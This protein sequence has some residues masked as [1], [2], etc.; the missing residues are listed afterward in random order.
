MPNGAEKAGAFDCS[1]AHLPSRRRYAPH[2]RRSRSVTKRKYQHAYDRSLSQS[3][4][5]VRAAVTS[6]VAKS[7]HRTPAVRA[8]ALSLLA[9]IRVLHRPSSLPPFPPYL[10][11][12]PGLHEREGNCSPAMDA[13]APDLDLRAEPALPRYVHPAIVRADPTTAGLPG[14]RYAM[15][16]T[17]RSS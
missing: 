10:D 11:D 9:V 6:A 5:D 17:L 7:W 3:T 13:R 14:L 16:W 15:S 1:R 12:L 2:G 4:L 8:R